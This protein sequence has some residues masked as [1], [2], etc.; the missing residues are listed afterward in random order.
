VNGAARR[1]ALLLLLLSF[2]VGS[3]AG[4]A[5]VEALGI[6][7][8]D[9]LDED[10]HGDADRLLEGLGL[11]RGQRARV[12]G[13]LDVQE[14][15]L[16][17]YWEARLPEIRAILEGSYAE[18]RVLR[19]PEQRTEFDRRVRELDGRAPLEVRD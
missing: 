10:A 2:S 4:M 3:L 1:V 5:L 11:S 6:D 19:T 9:F 13:I 7:W 14:D 8:F 17:D 15:R 12:E 18:I 16:E